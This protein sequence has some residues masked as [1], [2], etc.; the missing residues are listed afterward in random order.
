MSPQTV[1]DSTDGEWPDLPKQSARRACSE[2]P[3]VLRKKAEHFEPDQV[4]EF[5]E[6][7]IALNAYV[8]HCKVENEAEKLAQR[9]EAEEKR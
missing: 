2:E 8:L 1:I 7:R 6:W 3:L 4:R 5:G 9:A